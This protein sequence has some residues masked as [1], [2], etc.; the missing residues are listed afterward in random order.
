MATYGDLNRY[1]E[2]IYD[3]KAKQSNISR[4]ESLRR[5]NN[6]PLAESN[7]ILETLG[8]VN[9]K[10]EGL[11]PK[12]RVQYENI[13]KDYNKK[14][15]VEYNTKDHIIGDSK[16]L[17]FF[18]KSIRVILPSSEFLS[19]YGGSVGESIK[20]KMN[21]FDSF[22]T[23]LEG[24][25]Y[26]GNNK[27]KFILGKNRYNVYKNNASL[28]DA[29]RTQKYINAFKPTKDGREGI[30]VRQNWPKLSQ[31]EINFF[32]NTKKKGTPEYRAKEQWTETKNYYWNNMLV[33]ARKQN[34]SATFE[35]MKQEF[36]ELFVNNYF[37]RKITKEA[38]EAIGTGNYLDKLVNKNLNKAAKSQALKD[39][40]SNASKKQLDARIEKL[41]NQDRFRAQIEMDIYNFLRQETK[42]IKNPYIQKRG[43]ILPEFIIVN[44][45]GQNKLVRTYETKEA[46]TASQ[47]I[48]GMSQHIATLRHFPE[49][50][51]MGGKYKDGKLASDL[52]KLGQKDPL[53]KEYAEE[54]IGY[55]VENRPSSS[56]QKDGHRILAGIAHISAAI[57][58]SSPTSGIKNVLIGIPRA[59]ASF[60]LVNTAIGIKRGFSANSWN[61]ARA[62]GI[63]GFQ[64]KTLD[65]QKSGYGRFTMEKVFQFNLMTKTENFNRIV[66]MEAGK[67]YFNSQVN[68]LKGTG[69]L[70]GLG[71]K[72]SKRLMKDMCTLRSLD[73]L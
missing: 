60:G 33:E 12:N 6:V 53:L 62:K 70:K 31:K 42:Q 64:S 66:S 43:P 57:G 13:I 21:Y 63:L 5:E 67:L 37:T 18:Q 15:V 24:F 48:A 3:V 44:K 19:K 68:A 38:Y 52:V 51:G 36:D 47:Y 10:I 26:E 14:N 30:A 46:N 2:H 71:E 4:I 11:T 54:A 22:R 16:K 72:N 40:G 34:N 58:L 49:F 35:V 29:E 28:F 23:R 32:E 41:K 61:E 73:E 20:D 50:T 9:G 1:A 69:L 17:N 59:I 55:L 65:L 56:L 27:I 39:L 7:Q 8:S 25:G 45:K